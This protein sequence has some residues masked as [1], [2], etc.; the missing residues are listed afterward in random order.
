[1]CA[2]GQAS[3]YAG[4]IGRAREKECEQMKSTEYVGGGSMVLYVVQYYPGS[5]A[6]KWLVNTLV[7]HIVSCLGELVRMPAC[8]VAYLFSLALL[9]LVGLRFDH[10]RRLCTLRHGLLNTKLASHSYC[11]PGE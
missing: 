11:S 10:S 8:T 6:G 5:N 4:Q 3:E 9:A 7:K 2:T 1:M